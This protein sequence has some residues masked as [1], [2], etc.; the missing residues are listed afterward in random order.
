MSRVFNIVQV[1]R[2]RPSIDIVKSYLVICGLL[3]VVSCVIYLFTDAGSRA[4]GYYNMRQGSESN[5]PVTL[6]A[7]HEIKFEVP[8]NEYIP[9]NNLMQRA[10]NNYT[11]EFDKY[12]AFNNERKVPLKI[13]GCADFS[14]TGAK[15]QCNQSCAS[16]GSKL[17]ETTDKDGNTATYCK[18]N[19]RGALSPEG[20]M[21]HL[22]PNAKG[23]VTVE[24]QDLFIKPTDGSSEF[25][26]IGFVPLRE[27]YENNR[28]S[29]IEGFDSV[30]LSS[31]VEANAQLNRS[32]T[33]P[34]T[35]VDSYF[36]LVKV[37]SEDSFPYA[38][39]ELDL[40][41]SADK[42]KYKLQICRYNPKCGSTTNNS[43]FECSDVQW[44]SDQLA[45][46]G[47]TQADISQIKSAD[48]RNA[49]KADQQLYFRV[50]PK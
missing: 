43:C 50:V 47:D 24:K 5:K 37:Q 40:A 15:N 2:K 17:R 29:N 13:M 38:T 49:L 10:Q 26:I 30:R 44:Y 42:S 27:S 18:V 12:K 21:K 28:Y 4:E 33:L 16:S 14:R 45:F 7:S 46:R 25:P 48:I 36:N 23:V 32:I 8:I 39:V 6:H 9:I 1:M 34:L 11:L 20:M 41:N 31:K 35:N 22:K 3:I 19:N